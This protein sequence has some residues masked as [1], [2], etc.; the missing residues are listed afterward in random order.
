[1][2]IDSTLE[3]AGTQENHGQSAQTIPSSEDPKKDPSTYQLETDC[4]VYRHIVWTLTGVIAVALLGSLSL[5]IF[6]YDIPDIFLAFGSGALGALAGLLAPPAI[7][8]A[9]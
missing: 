7:R 2:V 9:Q 5:H 4:Y 6:A 3:Q 1:M 8:Q